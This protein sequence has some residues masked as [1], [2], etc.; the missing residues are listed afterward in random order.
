MIVEAEAGKFGDAE[1]FA[2]DAFGVI[3]VEDPVFDAGFYA[4]GA[5]EERGFGGFEELLRARKKRFARA[6]ELQFIAER[7]L[8]SGAGEFGSLEFTGREID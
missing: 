5:V 6:D 1:L 4:A 2:E 8:R 3:G 7:L